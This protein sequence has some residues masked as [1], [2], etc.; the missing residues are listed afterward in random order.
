MELKSIKKQMSS[1]M[2]KISFKQ[3]NFFISKIFDDGKKVEFFQ[4]WDKYIP[5]TNRNS[6]YV[7]RTKV[8]EL[9]LQIYFTIYNI[10]PVI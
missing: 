7:D 8:I 3:Q 4:L 9:K 6:P 1:A 5:I 10:H 2:N